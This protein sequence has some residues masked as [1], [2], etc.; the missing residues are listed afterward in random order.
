MANATV[1]Y[2]T[3]AE[4]RNIL[5]GTDMTGTA[6]Q[7]TDSQL[8]QA[9]TSG[10]NTVSAYAGNVWDVTQNPQ[11]TPPVILHDLA[12]DLAAWWASTTYLKFKQMGNDS[13]VVLKYTHAMKVLEDIRD[14]RV[15][16]D[17]D[18]PGSVGAESGHVLNVLLPAGATN[19]FSLE[20][21]NTRVNLASG[22]LEA[23]VPYDMHQGGLTD[24]WGEEYTG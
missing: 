17:V 6:A 12:L 8:T 15:R 2:A 18:V 14:G 22:Y 21:S 19:V 13:P 16:I 5:S 10:S 11:F 24:G 1:L 9:L 3:V 23:G 20:D 4:L 7:L